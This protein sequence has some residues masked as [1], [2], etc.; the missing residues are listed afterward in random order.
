[1]DFADW[2]GSRKRLCYG[3]VAKL[4]ATTT[5]AFLFVYRFVDVYAAIGLIMHG[6]QKFSAQRRE[7]FPRNYTTARSVEEKGQ[8]SAA[9]TAT[10]VWLSSLEKSNI[11]YNGKCSTLLH[12]ELSGPLAERCEGGS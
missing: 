9:T 11:D 7:N 10:K 12:S 3:E 8:K 4:A 5:R 6:V 2:Q 1:M